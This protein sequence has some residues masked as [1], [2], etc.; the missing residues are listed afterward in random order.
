MSLTTSPSGCAVSNSC[1][2]RRRGSV[3]RAENMSAYLATRSP[4]LPEGEGLLVAAMLRYYQNYGLCQA[5][6]SSPGFAG[7]IRVQA[8]EPHGL[9]GSAGKLTAECCLLY[10]G[11]R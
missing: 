2:M 11:S 5:D 4:D 9:R 3:P 8:P 6:S 1:M 7:P 10:S